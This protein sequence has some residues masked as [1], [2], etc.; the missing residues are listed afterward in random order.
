MNKIWRVYESSGYWNVCISSTRRYLF[1]LFSLSTV[2]SLAYIPNQSKLFMHGI[3]TRL[4]NLNICSHWHYSSLN[5]LTGVSPFHVHG[6][7]LVRFL[8]RSIFS[9][10]DPSIDPVFNIHSIHRIFNELKF[11]HSVVS[12]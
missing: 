6:F 8:F 4:V 10:V 11:V 7:C 9:F 1:W 2:F 3:C 12:S 5:K